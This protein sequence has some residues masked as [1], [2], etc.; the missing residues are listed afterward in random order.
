MI[1]SAPTWK[2]GSTV[3]LK[4]DSFEPEWR[5]ALIVIVRKEQLVLAVRVL[6]PE[7]EDR[8]E[9]V[10]FFEVKGM[11]FI[12][13]EGEK[14][15]MRAICPFPH[16]ALE[17]DAKLAL[18]RALETAENEKALY[19]TASEDLPEAGEASSRRKGL[20]SLLRDSGSEDSEEDGESEV[21]DNLLKMLGKAHRAMPGLATSSG[22]PGGK[23]EGSHPRFALLGAQPK[24]VEEKSTVEQLLN[25]VLADPSNAM[26]ASTLTTLVQMELLRELKGK[27]K[28]KTHSYN[29][30]GL[31]ASSDSDSSSGG[32]L[33]L[34]GAGKA[35]KAYR[36][37]QKDMKKN[38]ARHVKR[39]IKEVE[40]VLG[41]DASVPYLLTDYTRKLGWGKFRTLQRL[42]HALSTI[43]ETQLKGRTMEA[44][45]QIT[46]VLR[47]IHQCALDQ[48]NWQTAWLLTGMQD[49]LE[50]PRF[51]GEAQSLEVIAAY[52]KAMDDL[53]KRSTS[54]SSSRAPEEDG[55]AGAK[56]NKKGKKGQK[57]DAEPVG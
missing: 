57:P 19:A 14:K 40:Q 7:L 34:R 33:R 17:V 12:M 30:A 26:D 48:G 2:V 56:G 20:Q 50:K 39:Y 8:W 37:T 24:K 15:Q 38:P 49:P 9:K 55:S 54:S 10:S 25:R 4:L 13:V 1:S 35:L 47:S 44:T 31:V 51:G 21:E 36:K 6:D 27:K 16:R 23:L 43:L 3:Y 41:A 32:D 52:I 42:H 22:N 45:L 29:S 11:K 18:P 5:Q 28:K 46:Q 53:E